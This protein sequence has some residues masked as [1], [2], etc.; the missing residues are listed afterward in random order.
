VEILADPRRFAGITLGARTQRLL[1]QWVAE[2][3]KSEAQ[4]KAPANDDAAS[5]AAAAAEDKPHGWTC[6]AQ[7]PALAGCLP[8]LLPFNDAVQCISDKCASLLASLGFVCF[9][10]GRFT[11]AGLLKKFS[12]ISAGL[13]GALNVAAA[14]SCSPNSAGCPQSVCF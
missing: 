14:S 2:R 7:S 1:N 3:K 5:Q 4:A 6:L 11:G 8:T 9:L 10:I 12:A 13:Y